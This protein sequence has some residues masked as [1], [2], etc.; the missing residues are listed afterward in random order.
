LAQDLVGEGCVVPSLKLLG[1]PMLRRDETTGDLRGLREHNPT[2]D[3]PLRDASLA[4]KMQHDM[5]T[6][7]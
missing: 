6:P 7:I 2:P 3:T 4:H 5:E 1:A